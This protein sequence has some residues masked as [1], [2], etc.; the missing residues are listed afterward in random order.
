MKSVTVQ[1]ILKCQIAWITL[2][3]IL[4]SFAGIIRILFAF[5]LAAIIEA[6]LN[7]D[8]EAFYRVIIVACFMLF[9]SCLLS[10]LGNNLRRKYAAYAAV[11]HKNELLE[12]ILSTSSED[13]AAK[14]EAFYLNIL[15]DEVDII[16]NDYYI[17][18]PQIIFD[19]V[20]IVGSIIALLYINW[21]LFFV[22]LLLLSITAIIPNIVAKYYSKKLLIFTKMNEILIS[23]TKSLL[24]GFELIKTFSLN[25]HILRDYNNQNDSRE[26]SSYKLGIV[27]NVQIEVANLVGFSLHMGTIIAGIFFVFRGD[28]E[29]AM[30]FAAVQVVQTLVYP[31]QELMRRIGVIKGSRE[32]IA[33]HNEI[34]AE[35]DKTFNYAKLK[36]EKIS[37][38]CLKN[39]SFKYPNSTFGLNA[40]SY[41]F[42]ANKKYAIIGKS[43]SGKS[44]LLKLMMG[45]YSDYSG[46]LQ[47]NDQE[48][49]DI[50]HASLYEKMSLLHQNVVLL[51][52]TLSNNIKLFRD[53]DDGDLNETIRAVKLQT[54]YKRFEFKSL[55]ADSMSL[56][57]GGE[58]QRIAVAR[59]IVHNNSFVLL[60]EATSAID[61][62]TTQ[63]IYDIMLNLP[64]TTLIAVTHD[65]TDEL[66]ERFDAVLY[67]D[68]GEIRNVG[69]WAL[70]KET[71]N[72][73]FSRL[74]NISKEQV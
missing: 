62:E 18:V 58:K 36:A 6:S 4:L 23:Y 5:I 54:L 73:Q 67:L 37:T 19:V 3:A 44:T 39:I 24:S 32:L 64:N 8:L 47:I 72:P 65:W 1:N 63:E 38:I 46:R 11:N 10:L 31:L 42:E 41:T 9:F 74:H 12:K 69:K 14:S 52:D 61:P 55:R 21:I 26:R 56:I 2:S 48:I 15:N 27:N 29:I 20:L 68:D 25:R 16:K 70:I 57:S 59:S 13:Y 33:K 60:D 53:I 34:L 40:V 28:L 49:R 43:G 22:I 17:Q 71:I 51:E 45:Y 66:L 30:L 35:K 7:L 50:D